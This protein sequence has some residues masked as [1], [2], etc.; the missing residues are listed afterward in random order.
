MIYINCPA[1]HLVVFIIENFTMS[2]C[3]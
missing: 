2:S 1:D 3:H